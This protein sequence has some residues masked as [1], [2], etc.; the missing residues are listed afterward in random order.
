M[1]VQATDALL[2]LLDLASAAAEARGAD[3]LSP[4][5]V[6]DVAVALASDSPS[7]VPIRHRGVSSDL[8]LAL[9]RAGAAALADGTRWLDPGRVLDELGV[10]PATRDIAVERLDTSL[11]EHPVPP[12]V[13]RGMLISVGPAPTLQPVRPL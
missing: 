11:R 9:S 4:A 13:G 2:R 5:D 1:D 3:T 8:L 6:M 7:S 12:D 10:D